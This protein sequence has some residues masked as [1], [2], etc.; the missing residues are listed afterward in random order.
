M[1]KL[2]L[3]FLILVGLALTVSP[4]YADRG[5]D[6]HDGNRSDSRDH[7][8]NNH[9]H[10]YGRERDHGHYNPHD[11]YHY[12]NR[13]WA[14]GFPPPMWFVPGVTS[15]REYFTQRLVGY[16]SF[17]S[18]VFVLDQHVQCQDTWGIWIFIR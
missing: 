14:W 7:G 6:N 3:L 16:D 4:A 2:V 9:G 10:D 13:G 12:Y 17:G 15:C 11:G 1:K 18:P 5:H 8:Y